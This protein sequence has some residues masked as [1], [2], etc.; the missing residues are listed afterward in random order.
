MNNDFISIKDELPE[1]GKDIIGLDK[2]GDVHYCFRCNCHN[3][4]C[5][6]WRCSITGYGLIVNIISWKYE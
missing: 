1:K 4:N 2:S 5:I 6:E 3:P